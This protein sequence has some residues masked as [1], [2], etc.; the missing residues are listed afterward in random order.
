MDYKQ[1]ANSQ[2]IRDLN[3]T[4][5]FRLIYKHGPVSRKQLAENTGYSS[6]TISN[7]VRRLYDNYFVI[8][9]E[10]GIST[11][12][13]KPVYLTWNPERSYIIAVSIEVTKIRLIL[14]NLKLKIKKKVSYI[15]NKKELKYV[16]EKLIGGIDKIIKQSGISKEKIMGIGIAVPG[17]VDSEN[18]IINFAPNLYWKDINM[19]KYIQENYRLPFILENEARAAVVGE[20]EFVYSDIG[21][22]VFVSINEGIG[23]GIIFNGSLYRGSSGN[24]G[25]FG[26]IIIDSSG[27]ECHCGNNGCWET[28]ASLNYIKNRYH[29]LN[30][31]ILSSEQLIDK[32]EGGDKK[33]QNIIKETGENIGIGLVNIINSLSP[34]LLVI[35]GDILNF[36]KYIE[37]DINK[38]ISEKVFDLFKEKI[39]VKYSRLSKNA[40]LYGIARIVFD[41]RIEEEIFEVV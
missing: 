28:L 19:K 35:G 1:A 14:F 13:R 32:A 11:G 5:I 31:P 4:S 3:L 7:H 25:E 21:N 26:H 41:S 27:P 17:L 15:L 12:G 6:A 23:C 16:V 30:N 36:R 34:E 10:K 40:P 37:K 8:E 29:K 33:L 2:Y 22:I 9:T 38:I 20:S 24:A 18:G 39:A